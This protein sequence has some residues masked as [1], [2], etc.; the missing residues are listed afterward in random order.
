MNLKNLYV[1]FS[2]DFF[3]KIKNGQ[4]KCPKLKRGNSF[5]FFSSRL[6]IKK[7]KVRSLKTFFSICD[8]IFFYFVRKEFKNILAM[9]IKW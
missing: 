9:I 3:G 5:L 8:D 1:F 2:Q 7:I 6:T 4:K